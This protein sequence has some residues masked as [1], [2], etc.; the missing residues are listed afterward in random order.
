L[1]TDPNVENR[2][3]SL[4]QIRTAV[5]LRWS[6]FRFRQIEILLAL[7]AIAAYI[8]ISSIGLHI[9][10]TY[11][12]GLAYEGGQ[13][14]WRTGHPESV[15]TWI[16][17]PFLATVMA[18]VSQVMTVKTAATLDTVINCAI[19]LAATMV[20][21]AG[22]RS[23][24][25]VRV[26][27][28]TLLAFVI[29]API[30]SSIFWIQFNIIALALAAVGYA[31]AGRRPGLAGLLVALSIGIKPL[32]VLL[33]VALLWR[34]ET[35]RSGVWSLAWG[36]VLL[37]ASQ[38]FLAVRA[39]DWH[40]LSPLTQLTSF[41]DRSLPTSRGW[42]C[43]PQNYSPESLWCRLAGTSFWSI[44][45]LLITIAVLAVIVLAA[46]LISRRP[47]RSW[48]L[49]AFVCLLSP[50]LSPIAW[51]H[52]QILL[53]PMFLVLAYEYVTAGADLVDWAALAAA[54]AL[55][56]LTLRPFGTAP[57][58]L[59]HLLTGKAESGVLANNVYAAAA[60]AQFVL[61]A[62]AFIW[63]ARTRLAPPNSRPG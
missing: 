9:P 11:D 44:K 37:A 12:V 4:R 57:G 3:T 21:W 55:A 43:N 23:R 60:L 52:Y 61:L 53:A 20:V 25:S 29:Y 47:G 30:A 24:V 1:T 49:F 39:H 51:S 19:F 35:R 16:S 28:I 46:H 32:V 8:T 6:A 5:E 7:F 34:K 22:L 13:V 63:F 26:W 14:A 50:M 40:T 2:G 33:P 62:A 56:E 58:L 45:R 48:S 31:L 18:L 54:Y 17:T 10:K 15:S 59:Y 41:A 42:V 27:W 38:V 36:A